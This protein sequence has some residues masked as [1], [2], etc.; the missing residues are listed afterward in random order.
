MNAAQ[1]PVRTDIVR[2]GFSI[3]PL[4]MRP[5]AVIMLLV[6]IAALTSVEATAQNEYERDRAG[7]LLVR[8]LTQL[9]TGDAESAVQSLEMADQLA[10]NEPGILAAI[11]SAY[12]DLGDQSAAQFYI[13]RALDLDD[14]NA[15]LRLQYAEILYETGNPAQASTVYQ[16][17]IDSHAGDISVAT[18]AAGRLARL[19]ETV[20]ATGV[21]AD[22]LFRH[23]AQPAILRMLAEVGLASAPEIVDAL[24]AIVQSTGVES[25]QTNRIREWIVLNHLDLPAL[26]DRLWPDRVTGDVDFA[27]DD[28]SVRPI[29]DRAPEGAD[30]LRLQDAID[31]NPRDIGN[32]IDA[33]R[34]FID[35]GRPDDAWRIAE[36]GLLLF[37]Y[38][39]DLLRLG[40][41]SALENSRHDLARQLLDSADPDWAD[42]AL[43]RAFLSAATNDVQSAMNYL[44]V[45]NGRPNDVVLLSYLAM[46]WSLLGDL[47][48][49]GTYASEAIRIAP[50]HPIAL[51]ASARVQFLQG[52]ASGAVADLERSATIGSP[53]VRVNTL[54]SEVL[55]RLGR[56]DDAAR[57]RARHST[58]P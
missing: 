50:S 55:D 53:R 25:G 31:A 47:E 58:Q 13:E 46:T 3:V 9:E 20:T 32:W 54:V 57:A 6:C 39:P 22:L 43:L 30:I 7:R 12:S 45:S 38:N 14:D 34:T 56:T 29:E 42:V 11:A 5:F 35:L 52:D 16:Q 48:K 21:L 28:V 17:V 15:E 4:V 37:P 41:V 44:S 1:K 51:E 2:K 33:A 23:G 40:A 10:P 26:T 49:A 36:E 8:G 18:F 19:G 27:A 24:D